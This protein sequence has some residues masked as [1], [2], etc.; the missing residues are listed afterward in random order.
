MGEAEAQTHSAVAAAH[1]MSWS[2][3]HPGSQGPVGLEAQLTVVL[4]AAGHRA[5]TV[6]LISCIPKDVA[7][8]PPT[9]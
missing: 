3:I 6:P 8:L 1:H 5:P 7:G 9:T 4:E 2:D